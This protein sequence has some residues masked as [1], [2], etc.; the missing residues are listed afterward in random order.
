M[1]RAGTTPASWRSSSARDTDRRSTRAVDRDGRER[2]CQ[3]GSHRIGPGQGR[4]LGVRQRVG[5][6]H[7]QDGADDLR[8][9]FP[10]RQRYGWSRTDV[11]VSF[12]C[13]DGLSGVETC[14]ADQVVT[15][16]AAASRAAGRRPTR[17]ATPRVRPSRASASTGPDRR[18]PVA[19][20]RSPTRQDGTIHRVTVSFTC[21]DALSGV[22][23]CTAN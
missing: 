4:Q 15:A 11:T 18:S 2:G 10:G 19:G 14:S 16:E 8:L 23:A 12:I 9:A 22:A 13:A 6:Q 20:C 21:N 3:S 1:P 5:H 7:R 17:P